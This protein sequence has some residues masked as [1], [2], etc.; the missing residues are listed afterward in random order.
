M[1]KHE[2]TQFVAKAINL[3]ETQAGKTINAFNLL[4][5][6]VQRQSQMLLQCREKQKTKETQEPPEHPLE[7]TKVSSRP[8][9][10]PLP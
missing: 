5:A 3:S 7:L 9:Q 6:I 4:H 2:L 8:L 10:L 1:N